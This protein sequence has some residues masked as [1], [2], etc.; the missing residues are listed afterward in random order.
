MNKDQQN[1][2]R[3]CLDGAYSGA[4]DFP[5]II[6]KLMENG[7]EGYSM[8]FR[9]HQAS[10]YSLDGECLSLDIPESS[11]NIAAEFNVSG[12]QAAI[13]KAQANEAG[14]TYLGFLEE[15][16]ASGCAGYIVSISGKRVVY[17]GRTA[18]MHVEHFP[19]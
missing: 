13:Q 15:V 14:Y 10:Y 19:Q 18:E 12:V 11:V 4:L 17:Y 1:I 8:D 9:A 5:Q 2:A 6:G 16:K 3:E 7:F